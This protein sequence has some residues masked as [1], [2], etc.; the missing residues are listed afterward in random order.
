[1]P[2]ATLEAL[3]DRRGARAASRHVYNASAAVRCC[4]GCGRSVVSRRAGAS[5]VNTMTAPCHPLPGDP[6]VQ[7]EGGARGV[8]QRAAIRAAGAGGGPA[9]AGWP[10]SIPGLDGCP[11]A[12]RQAFRCGP[13]PV[14]NPLFCAAGV[15][16]EEPAGVCRHRRDAPGAHGAAPQGGRAGG[17][18][19]AA[20]CVCTHVCVLGGGRGRDVRGLQGGRGCALL[21]GARTARAARHSAWHRHQ[22]AAGALDAGAPRPA[23]ARAAIWPTAHP[24]T[25]TPQPAAHYGG[26]ILVARESAISG[27]GVGELIDTWEPVASPDAVQTPAEVY[28]ALR[29]EGHRVTYFR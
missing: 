1:M 17:G 6:V 16:A 21:H 9:V 23:P 28:R 18:G 11:H 5:W 7:H 29:A 4:L 10:R 24:S 13:R 27:G 25:P 3:P 26:R 8:R 19:C 20:L 12:A 14:A 15:P 2:Q 22:A